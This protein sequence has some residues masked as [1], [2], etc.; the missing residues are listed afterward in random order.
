M[1]VFGY[2]GYVSGVD[3]STVAFS[4]QELDITPDVI[5]PDSVARVQQ[6][7]SEDPNHQTLGPFK[8]MAYHGIHAL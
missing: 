6:L 4:S 5:V 1:K 7:L 3:I 2:E 8:A